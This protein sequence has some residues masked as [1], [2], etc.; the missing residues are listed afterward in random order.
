MNNSLVVF[1]PIFENL[2]LQFVYKVFAMSFKQHLNACIGNVGE[3]LSQSCLG[4]WV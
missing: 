3:K 2:I 4:S 1:K